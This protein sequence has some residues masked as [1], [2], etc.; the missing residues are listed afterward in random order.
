M[1]Y[2]LVEK[3]NPLKPEI[4]KKWYANP[5]NQGVVSKAQVS[6]EIAG[7]SSLTSGDISNVL[8]N[9][10][11]ELPKYLIAGNSVKLG[12]F[13]TFRLSISGEGSD[14][15]EGYKASNIKNAKVIF[16][17][18]AALKKALETIHYEKAE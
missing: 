15:K 14:T 9:L 1:K 16:T 11:E 2:K 17:P 3:G 6:K 5:I 10:I 7:R 12:E 8:E 13:G 4:P 18:G